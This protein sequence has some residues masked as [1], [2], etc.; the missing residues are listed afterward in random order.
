M[1]DKKKKIISIIAAI[2]ALI[3]I[4]A[5]I[6]NVR[7]D[8][9]L[10]KKQADALPVV[11]LSELFEIDDINKVDK[12]KIEKT[13]D[14]KVASKYVVGSNS[15]KA[16]ADVQL[17]G[18]KGSLYFLRD[19]YSKMNIYQTKYGIDELGSI[20]SQVS[21]YMEEFKMN[22]TMLIGAGLEED[23]YTENLY[24][25]DDSDKDIPLE[26]SIYNNNRLYSISYKIDEGTGLEDNTTNSDVTEQN[27]DVKKYD[28]NFYRDGSYLMCEL[29]KIF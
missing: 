8:K 6:I 2:V 10:K 12:V 21:R 24:N 11:E 20:S 29:V 16:K 13:S 23:N 7:V 28:I 9:E 15:Y 19:G 26:E 4:Y 22:C 1:K 25:K 17:E 5:I 27:T 3:V 14:I 18:R